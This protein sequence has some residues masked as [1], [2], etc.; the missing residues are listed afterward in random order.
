MKWTLLIAALLAAGAIV[1]CTREDK[2]S[3]LKE[4]LGEIARANEIYV[5][6]LDKA[7]NPEE[8]AVAMKTMSEKLDQLAPV[9]EKMEKKYPHIK[10]IDR[11][12]PPEELR[13]ELERINRVLDRKVAVSL[14]VMRYMLDPEVIKAAEELSGKTV[15]LALFK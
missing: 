15:R 4:Y 1:G 2:Y 12:N 9:G 13:P 5:N 14:K 7:S 3:D 10:N 8:V 11:N 6:T